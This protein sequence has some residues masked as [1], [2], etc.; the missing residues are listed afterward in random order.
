VLHRVAA[1]ALALR[2]PT[3][4]LHDFVL[5]HSGGRKGKLDIKR[6][7]MLPIV[8]LARWA[9]LS[10]GVTAGPTLER[11]DGA[12][13]AG[14]LAR[15]DA[16]VLREAFEL[17][18]ALRMEHQIERLREG[19]VPDDLVDP[20]HLRPLARSSLKT[21]FRAVIRVQR[22]ISVTLSLSPR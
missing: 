20:A 15:A 12:E 16:D 18:C 3:G 19:L 13:A 10:A 14:V 22:G 21:A 6:G 1:S 9:A 7:G 8:N 4:L 2:P 11:L 5:E 17:A